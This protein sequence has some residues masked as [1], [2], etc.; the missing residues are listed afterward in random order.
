MSESIVL[1]YSDKTKKYYKNGVLHR[2]GDLPAIECPNRALYYKNGKLHRDG[3]LPAG[4]YLNGEER[5]Y[6]NG[7]L[8]RDFD[9][10]AVKYSDGSKYYYK[11][12]ALHR[13]HGLPAIESANDCK[14][15]YENGVLHRG[16]GL[17]AI[18]FLDR[19]KSYYMYGHKITSDV[20]N[21]I[22]K[23]ERAIVKK[24]FRYWYDWT[25]SDPD[26]TAFKA[27]LERDMAEYEEITGGFFIEDVPTFPVSN[28]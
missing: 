13:D 1:N 18:E 20:A 9:L 28:N 5:Y 8:H 23:R 22:A 27:R 2:D 12:G 17:P 25:Y 11:N 10:P 26:N 14:Y 16:R 19:Y 21:F 6:K 15:Y 24:A 4:I 3:D 7:K